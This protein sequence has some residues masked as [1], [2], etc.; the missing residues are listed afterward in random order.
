MGFF[1]KKKVVVDTEL[2][3]ERV[4]KKIYDMADSMADFITATKNELLDI[5]FASAMAANVS[6]KKLAEKYNLDGLEKFSK[7][8]IKQ[9]DIRIKKEKEKYAKGIKNVYDKAVKVAKKTTP[10]KKKSVKKAK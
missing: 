5:I 2:E 9:V 4:E 3:L 6:P 10:R 8:L 7:E 1:T